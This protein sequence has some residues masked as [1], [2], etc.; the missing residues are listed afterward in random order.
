MDHDF[1]VHF[2]IYLECKNVQKLL[3]PRWLRGLGK[4]AVMKVHI[5]ASGNLCVFYALSSRSPLLYGV[6]G[7]LFGSYS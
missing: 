1:H 7:C 2:Y 4:V 5:F 6:I 3:A